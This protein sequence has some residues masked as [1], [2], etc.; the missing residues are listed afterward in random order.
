MTET[1]T[2]YAHRSSQAWDAAWEAL[3]TKIVEDNLGDGSD[4]VQM[5]PDLGEGWQYMGSQIAG[6]FMEHEFRHRTHPRTQVREYRRVRTAILST[7]GV[8]DEIEF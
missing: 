4:L 8:P 3:R 1:T 6:T 7:Q 2:I 5:H